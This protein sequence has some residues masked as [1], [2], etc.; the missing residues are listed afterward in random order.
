MQS[1]VDYNSGS[2]HCK[3]FRGLIA[4]RQPKEIVKIVD[5]FKKQL[6]AAESSYMDVVIKSGGLLSYEEIMSMPVD[7]IALFIKRL[8]A[9]REEQNQAAKTQRR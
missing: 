3:F 4:S 7:S 6:E 8:N 2:R 9:V 5:G 1:Y